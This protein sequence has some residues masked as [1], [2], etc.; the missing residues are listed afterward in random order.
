MSLNKEVYQNN[1]NNKTHWDQK[2]DENQV[3]AWVV[4]TLSLGPMSLSLFV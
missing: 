1:N 3:Y 4:L 2:G